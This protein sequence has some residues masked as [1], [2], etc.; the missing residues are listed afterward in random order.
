MFLVLDRVLSKTIAVPNFASESYTDSNFLRGAILGPLSINSIKKLECSIF[1]SQSA[2]GNRGENFSLQII[3]FPSWREK[4]PKRDRACRV[5]KIGL[6]C[7]YT[8]RHAEALALHLNVHRST[9]CGSLK[10]RAS[11]AKSRFNCG[12]RRANRSGCGIPSGKLIFTRRWSCEPQ[13]F[14][15]DTSSVHR[16]IKRFCRSR[17]VCRFCSDESDV[18][19][20]REG[21]LYGR[22]I[23]W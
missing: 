5:K 7:I 14:F 1:C 22:R 10:T 6:A 11:E 4:N 18:D 21:T 20:K 16:G 15:A 12:A 17:R 3:G 2:W 9:W 19:S 23:T 8:S 13:T